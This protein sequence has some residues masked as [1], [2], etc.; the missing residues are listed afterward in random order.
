MVSVQVIREMEL[1]EVEK[2]NTEARTNFNVPLNKK[3]S[4]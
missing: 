1:D 2:L 3:I 4:K